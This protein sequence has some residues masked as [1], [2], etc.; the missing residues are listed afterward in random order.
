VRGLGEDSRGA[1]V[2]LRGSKET[3]ITLPSATVGAGAWLLLLLGLVVSGVCCGAGDSASWRGGSFLS[4]AGP[5]NPGRAPGPGISQ[6]L[7]GLLGA[8]APDSIKLIGSKI[9]Q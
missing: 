1:G 5:I 3:D 6:Y 7:N 8:K 2:R 9:L 4:S